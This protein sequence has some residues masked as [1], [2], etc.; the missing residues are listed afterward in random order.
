MWGSPMVPPAYSRLGVP[1]WP[2]SQLLKSLQHQLWAE[3]WECDHEGCVCTL[4]CHNQQHILLYDWE[5]HCQS[6]GGY[7]SDRWV[8]P[9]FLY[10]FIGGRIKSKL[11]SNFFNRYIMYQGTESSRVLETLMTI[12][13]GTIVRKKKTNTKQCFW[14]IGQR[15]QSGFILYAFSLIG[16]GCLESSAYDS[17]PY[18]GGLLWWSSGEATIIW[19][20][21]YIQVMI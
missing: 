16:S 14:H 17:E 7:Q 20:L 15:R 10:G 18:S 11:K 1:G 19:H 12:P 6:H 3:L 21:W 13:A 5:Q 2:G 8:P 4:Q 9:P